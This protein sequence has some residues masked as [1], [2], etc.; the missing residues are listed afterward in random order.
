MHFS[1]I[2]GLFILP[3]FLG[4]FCFSFVLFTF[5]AFTDST[6][7]SLAH[8][9]RP[10]GRVGHAS[11]ILSYW[12]LW[13]NLLDV[14]LLVTRQSTDMLKA[15][16]YCFLVSAIAETS[17]SDSFGKTVI[18]LL[19]YRLYC[20]ALRNAIGYRM[21]PAVLSLFPEAEGSQAL[22]IRT[23]GSTERQ[24]GFHCCCAVLHQMVFPTPWE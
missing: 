6:A 18:D 4:F 23:R 16:A 20:S 2:E 13:R 11:F 21:F 14:L 7:T 9:I 24:S 5:Q 3:A 17:L 8:C 19:I 15:L 1:F 22:G 12:T 10:E